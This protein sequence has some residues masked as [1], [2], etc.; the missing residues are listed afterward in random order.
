M[1]VLITGSSGLIG[2]ALA[3]SMTSNGHDVI[4]LLSHSFA[5]DS[6]VWSPENG[7]MELEDVG[8]ITAVV[9]L[10]SENIADGRWSVSKKNRILIS[11]VRVTQLLAEYFADSEQKPQV[12]ISA[13]AVGLYGD[14]G[15]EIVDEESY[16]VKS[17]LANVCVQW[18]DALNAAVE[19]VIRVVKSANEV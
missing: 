2:S 9:H 8:E 10:A 13:S 15:T 11:R 4:R 1:K 16:A 18:V 17:F 12:I 7:V 3:K 14:R 6:P 19:T 5:N